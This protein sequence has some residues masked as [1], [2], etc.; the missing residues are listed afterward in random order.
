MS[1]Q[2]ESIIRRILSGMGIPDLIEI[3]N[4]IP[5]K[6]F[7]SLL[8]RVMAERVRAKPLSE[9]VQAADR[10][11]F[12]GP[13]T[14][15]QRELQRFNEFF[16]RVVPET[17]TAIELSPV[18]PLGLNAVLTRV[19][20][21]KVLS[22]LRGMEIVA[23][24]TTALSLEAARRRRTL[25]E[26]NARDSSHV[27]LCTCHRIL[28]LQPFDK[29]L[30]YMQHFNVFALCT[31]GRAL[32]G[33]E[34]FTVQHAL[35]HLRIHLDL[36]RVLNQEGFNCREIS[37]Y[38]SDIRL[39]DLLIDRAS[40][41]RAVVL[42]QVLNPDFR[43][44]DLLQTDLPP[45][46]DTIHQ[47]IEQLRAYGLT[48]QIRL[49]SVL[50]NDLL[51]LLRREYPEIKVGLDLARIAGLGYYSDFC[52]HIYATNK[53]GRQI[54]LSDGG[55]SDW[56]QRLLVNRKERVLTSGFG[57]ELVQRSFRGS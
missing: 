17:F 43:A 39:M 36:V 22:S 2:N 12:F 1:E 24:P 11:E 52:F 26:K 35:R 21:N 42:R 41:D 13:S 49:F 14:L 34:A 25:F 18:N 48:D 37:V 54:Q 5:G 27:D 9:I 31:A 50:E 20:Q 45:R 46:T 15:S 51:D 16:Y 6:D 32:A 47:V 40:I 53:D 3:L 29:S 19:S 56:T 44:F 7:Q 55:V 38:V 30:G 28:R 33:T 4:R 23:D 8:L 10:E 57:A